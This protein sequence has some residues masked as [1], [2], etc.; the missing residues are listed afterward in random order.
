MGGRERQTEI[1]QSLQDFW[2]DYLSSSFKYGWEDKEFNVGHDRCQVPVW[3]DD[4]DDENADNA[5]L[6]TFIHCFR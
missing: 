1:L 2:F 4:D 3:S 6:L 5:S